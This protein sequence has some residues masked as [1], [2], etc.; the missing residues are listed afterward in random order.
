MEITISSVDQVFN[1]VTSLVSMQVLQRY[2]PTDNII[3][4]IRIFYAVAQI[5]NLLLMYLIKKKIKLVDDKRTFIVKDS[6]GVEK[7]HSYSDYDS[8]ELS[9]LVKSTLFQIPI[10]LFLHFKMEM[11]QPLLMQILMTLKNFVFSPLINV[12]LYNEMLFQI[13]RPFEETVIFRT[14][15]AEEEDSDANENSES[16]K[17]TPEKQEKVQDITEKEPFERKTSKVVEDEIDSE[18][19]TDKKI[20][21]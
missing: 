13:S 3:M 4:F 2:K 15:A 5:V 19:E 11:P 12:Y 7:Q 17:K 20:E 18:E 21:E 9:K 6:E 14:K 10:V 8:E 1:I 16:E